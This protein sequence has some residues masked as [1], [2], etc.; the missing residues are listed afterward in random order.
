M[1]N[2]ITTSAVAL[3]LLG[4]CATSTPYASNAEKTYGYGDQQIEDNRWM[5]SFSGNSLTDRQT[6]ETY[7]LYRAAELTS[8]AGFDYFRVV[9]RDT[10]S[11]SR[12]L[13]TGRHFSPYYSGFYPSYGFFGHHGFHRP[14]HFGGFGHGR[15]GYGFGASDLREITRY[16]ANA[17]I[18]MGRGQ[19]PPD[20]PAYF[21]ADGVLTNLAGKIERP[22]A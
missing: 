12:F 15:Y 3:L 11:E 5:V 16:E 8:Q 22:E 4:G 18:I 1:R 9:Q 17:E 19:K 20:D 10:D 2:A 21:D 6:V 7:L 14:H 13:S